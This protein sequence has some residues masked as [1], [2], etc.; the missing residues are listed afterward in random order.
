[1]TCHRQSRWPSSSLVVF[2]AS[3]L[4]AHPP[5]IHSDAVASAATSI[6]VSSTLS[7]TCKCKCKCEGCS[8]PCTGEPSQATYVRGE[9]HTHTHTHARTHTHAHA[10]T[11]SRTCTLTLTL[12]RT[13]TRTRTHAQRHKRTHAGMNADTQAYLSPMCKAGEC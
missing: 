13:R 5:V 12:T 6:A 2:L 1:M 4:A 10:Y 8:G 3:L 7:L 11:H 9:A